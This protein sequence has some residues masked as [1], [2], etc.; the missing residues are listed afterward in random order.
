MPLS[1]NFKIGFKTK[2]YVNEF[3]LND[4]K[5][6][7]NITRGPETRC[8]LLKIRRFLTYLETS[9]NKVPE[10]RDG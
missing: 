9:E 2:E 10:S 8:L 4:Q 7:S 3:P 6:P 5:Q 1:Q